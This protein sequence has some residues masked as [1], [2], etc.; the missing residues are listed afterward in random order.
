M[1]FESKTKKWDIRK[2]KQNIGSENNKEFMHA[3]LGCDIV[4]QIYNVAKDKI[5]K[6]QIVK[7][8]MMYKQQRHNYVKQERTSF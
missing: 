2:M 8:S 7:F 4:T 1:I 3:F 5:L 6:A